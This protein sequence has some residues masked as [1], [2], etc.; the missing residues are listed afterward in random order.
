MAFGGPALPHRW[1][2][3]SDLPR[4]DTR[5]TYDFDRQIC[6]FDGEAVVKG[7]NNTVSCAG[8]FSIPNCIHYS[9]CNSAAIFVQE[10]NSGGL[11]KQNL[12]TVV[13][14]EIFSRRS[15]GILYAG[16]TSS[17]FYVLDGYRELLYGDSL[18]SLR[19]IGLDARFGD[20]KRI[21][22]SS[23]DVLALTTKGV[24]RIEGGSVKEQVVVGN[25]VSAGRSE[26][27]RMWVMM[28]GTKNKSLVFMM[29]NGSIYLSGSVYSA[30]GVTNDGR[31]VHGNLIMSI[32][33]IIE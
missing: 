10:N 17:M 1:R 26:K 16:A 30:D 32:S 7:D 2:Q 27:H 31:I 8:R 29:D 6:S 33:P 13:G 18:R 21:W 20:V 28:F 12:V 4:T 23:K 11:Y 19:R 25:V 14:D 24:I 22:C 15:N 5:T 3:V 9:V